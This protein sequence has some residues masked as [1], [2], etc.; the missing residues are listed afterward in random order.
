MKRKEKEVDVKVG[1]DVKITLDSW[2]FSEWKP[3]KGSFGTNWG[4][5]RHT[6]TASPPCVLSTTEYMACILRGVCVCVRICIYM[7][8]YALLCMD[9]DLLG[10]YSGMQVNGVL[11]CPL[12]FY[13]ISS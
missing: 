13:I 8:I 12:S 4:L 2:P 1:E 3:L 5:P 9:I 11:R 7:Y 6:P 10:L